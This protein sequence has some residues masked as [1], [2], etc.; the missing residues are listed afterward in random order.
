MTYEII[1]SR[2]RC[3]ECNG[4]VRLYFNQHEAAEQEPAEEFI[5]HKVLC[6]DGH[7]IPDAD[8]QEMVEL[9]DEEFYGAMER[10][11]KAAEIWVNPEP[12]QGMLPFDPPQL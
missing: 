9:A 6:E 3:P 4:R 12:D 11:F 8:A 5:C 2:W 1:T 7:V 10:G